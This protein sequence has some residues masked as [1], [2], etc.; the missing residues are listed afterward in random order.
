VTSFNGA[1]LSYGGERM[2]D[3]TVRGD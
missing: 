3:R 1:D 2:E